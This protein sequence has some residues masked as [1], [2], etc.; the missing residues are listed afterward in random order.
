MYCFH[1]AFAIPIHKTK[2]QIVQQTAQNAIFLYY[3]I[4]ILN[5][6]LISPQFCLQ[7][8]LITT[9]RNDAL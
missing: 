9:E 3:T 8:I 7:A 2:L 6:P 1:Q 5:C 4:E